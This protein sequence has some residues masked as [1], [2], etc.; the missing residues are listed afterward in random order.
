MVL[1]EHLRSYKRVY[2]TFRHGS[3]QL[4]HAAGYSCL[5]VMRGGLIVK[6]LAVLPVAVALCVQEGLQVCLATLL[7]GG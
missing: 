6:L 7:L 4:T 2:C 1:Y 3:L 5:S